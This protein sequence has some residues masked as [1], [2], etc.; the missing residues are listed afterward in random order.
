MNPCQKERPIFS[1][2]LPIKNKVTSVIIRLIMSL[3]IFIV[4]NNEF[5][6]PIC[7]FSFSVFPYGV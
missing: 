2:V 7:V 6:G 1:K 5:S 3:K 4:M